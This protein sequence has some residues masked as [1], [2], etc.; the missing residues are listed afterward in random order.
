MSDKNEIL[1]TIKKKKNGKSII[2]G[3]PTLSP[4]RDMTS[5]IKEGLVYLTICPISNNRAFNGKY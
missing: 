5:E 3:C 4:H 2:L 1:Q